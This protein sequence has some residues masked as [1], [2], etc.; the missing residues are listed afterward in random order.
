MQNNFK[1]LSLTYHKAPLAVREQVALT[2]E[3]S[4]QLI[5]LIQEHTI[6]SD[7]LVL[8][9]C[10]RTEIYYSASEE[11]TDTLL[12]LLAAL[13]GI[14]S[15]EIRPFFKATTQGNEAVHYLFRVALGLE[16]QVIGD[17]QISNQ[18]KRAYQWS[19]DLNMA[20]P[21]LHRLMHT[22]FF[23]NK[24][25]VQQT[26][27]RDGAASVSYAAAELID[28]LSGVIHDPRVLVIGLGEI[29]ADVC[30]HLAEEPRYQVSITNRT[31]QKAEALAEECGFTVIPFE[32]CQDAIAHADVVICSIAADTPFISQ[33]MVE[34]MDIP[35]YKIFVDLSVP[36]S[37]EGMVDH[38]P[39]VMLYNIDDIRTQATAALDRRKAAIPEVEQLILEAVDEFQNWTRD[40]LVSP[41]IHRMK[42]AL[43]HIRQ[44]ELTR[45]MKN[46]NEKE[47]EVVNDITRSMMQKVMKL[48]VLQLKA[49]CQRGDADNL[50]DVLN[51]LFNLEKEKELK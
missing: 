32:D 25:V 29:G 36:R 1:V 26:A 48:P 17:L 10:N 5:Q 43:E 8:S 15:E 27:F 33:Q 39:G 7:V 50:I 47:L 6:A 22:I 13:K 35:G 20:G 2:E 34:A 21:F 9:T 23:T 16:A 19:A 44:E 40:M 31:L 28:E 4:K 30:R 45:Y 24:K 12:G 49:A 11:L 41:T 14:K 46:L 38:V 42:E 18:V 37:I 3:S 51:D